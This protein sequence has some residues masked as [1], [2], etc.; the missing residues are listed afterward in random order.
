M[1]VFCWLH[2]ISGLLALS[3][4]VGIKR[5]W[6]A[7]FFVSFAGHTVGGFDLLLACLDSLFLLLLLVIG[8]GD[9]SIAMGLSSNR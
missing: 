3:T 1:E 8:R 2:D 4:G 7:C 9:V 5:V 6:I